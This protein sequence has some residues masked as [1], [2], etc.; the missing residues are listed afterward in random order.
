MTSGLRAAAMAVILVIALAASAC[1]SSTS[2]TATPPSAA[3]EGPPATAVASPALPTATAPPLAPTVAA[4]TPT[5]TAES[6]SQSSALQSTSTLAGRLAGEAMDFLETFTSDVSPRASGTEQ[7][8]AAAEY[9]A[10]ELGALGYTVALQPFAVDIVSSSIEL[11]GPGTTDAPETLNLPL[12]LSGLGRASGTLVYVGEAREGDLPT[13]SLQGKVALVRRGVI[14]F[15]AKVDR[16]TK[17]GASAAIIYNNRPGLFRGTLVAESSI[18]VVSVSGDAGDS[19]RTLS[20]SGE[21]EATVSVILTTYQSHN[22]VAERR[23]VNDGDGVVILGGHYDTVPDVPGANDNGSG[24]ATLITV[25]REVSERAYP[26]TLRLIAFG[27]EELGL[28][29]SSFHV[30]SLSQVERESTIAMLNFDA[31]GTGDVTGVL[32]DAE[33]RSAVLQ[34]AQDEGIVAE[35]R[36]A[37]SPGTSS[38]HEP[39]RTAGI[40]VLFFLA[41]EFSRIHTPE[42]RLEFV[43]PE[44]MGDSAALAV[45]LLD[46]LARP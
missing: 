29:G 15:A 2:P 31:L 35:A 16:L 9:L 6:P 30:D 45:G 18:P 32:G 8:L 17:A 19:L 39:F 28:H 34:I 21:V 26:F 13:Q 33:L 25:A 37:L 3:A 14:T 5:A 4:S 22:V 24:I 1:G 7:E 27:M 43:R 38:D 12:T 44:L 20:S 10:G 46:S 23:G 36:L 42:D 41:D 11:H 40:P